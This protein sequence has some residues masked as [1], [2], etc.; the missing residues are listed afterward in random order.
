MPRWGVLAV[1]APDGLAGLEF[2]TGR[3]DPEAELTT[4]DARWQLWAGTSID[5]PAWAS[6]SFCWAVAQS[7]G[8]SNPS[9]RSAA[10]RMTWMANSLRP[11]LARAVPI[12][13][14]A[15]ARSAA[16][17]VAGELLVAGGRGGE[18]SGHF[19]DHCEGE[20]DLR[21]STGDVEFGEHVVRRS[22]AVWR[23]SSPE[24]ALEASQ[25]PDKT[26]EGCPP[27]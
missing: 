15:R 13:S 6:A 10:W 12:E 19:G 21:D 23:S 20:F 17:F 5:R 1:Q 18:A 25:S 3:L 7:S 8:S 9:N 4:R 11:S 14:R 27:P 16:P 26:S 24:G 2:T 22:R